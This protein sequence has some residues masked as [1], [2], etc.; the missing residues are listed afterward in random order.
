AA[1]EK[2]PETGGVDLRKGHVRRPDLQRDDEVSK[3]GKGHRHNTE[4]DHDRA[5]HSAKRV[6]ELW[7][8][9]AARHRAGAKEVAEGVADE[10]QCL[11]GIS[12]LPAH[13]H[14]QGKTEEEEDEAAEAVLDTDDLVVA[15]ENVF[16]PKAEFVML[17]LGVV[18]RIV[19]CVRVKM[20]SRVHAR[21]NLPGQISRDKLRLQSAK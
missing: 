16:S 7:R 9:F 12:Q 11:P 19:R 20:S 13:Q 2:C 18:M 15:G 21:E 1:D 4:K 6:V 10:R 17:V 5:V 3:S 14:H 8:H